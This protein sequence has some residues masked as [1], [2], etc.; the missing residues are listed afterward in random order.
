MCKV[1]LGWIGERFGFLLKRWALEHSSTSQAYKQG[2]S[3]LAHQHTVRVNIGRFATGRKMM[4][5][6]RW[7]SLFVCTWTSICTGKKMQ[8]VSPTSPSVRRIMSEW[9]TVQA[10]GLAMGEGPQSASGN[11]SEPFRLKPV[12]NMFEWHFTFLG[13]KGSPFEGGLYHGSISLPPDYPLSGPSVR[14]L[15]K[16]QRFKVGSRICLS[17]SE[18]HQETWQ[19]SWTVSSLVAALVAHMTEPAVEIG[20]VVGATPTQKRAA[21]LRSRSFECPTCGCHHRAFPTDVFPLP[22]K[23]EGEGGSTGK[24]RVGPKAPDR[25]YQRLQTPVGGVKLSETGWLGEILRRILTG[26]FCIV[27]LLLVAVYCLNHGSSTAL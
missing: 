5:W 24:A 11:S 26:R 12:G 21:A 2:G 25:G 14:L 23:V 13:A 7:G 16:N 20:S 17:A 22:E 19:P 6:V 27:L 10:E 1:N 9:K 15:N 3:R 18:Y 8:S 4:R